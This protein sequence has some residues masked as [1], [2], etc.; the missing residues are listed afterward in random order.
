MLCPVC[1]KDTLS[2]YSK[3]I[4]EYPCMNP[5]CAAHRTCTHVSVNTGRLD[6]D[7]LPSP[8]G[9][10]GPRTTDDEII[11]VTALMNRVWELEVRVEELEAHKAHLITKSDEFSQEAHVRA[12]ESMNLRQINEE[13]HRQ[14][15]ALQ[16]N[17]KR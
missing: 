8:T 9:P 13:L 15:D 12:L 3:F 11:D 14:I 17:E 5:D 1:G 10:V 7:G 2:I 4:G 6:Y 16:S